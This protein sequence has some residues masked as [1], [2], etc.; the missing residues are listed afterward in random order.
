[1]F[2]PKLKGAKI[3][4]TNPNPTNNFVAQ[5]ITLNNDDYNVLEIIYLQNLTQDYT[6]SQ[7]FLKTTGTVLISTEAASGLGLGVRTRK[8]DYNSNNLIVQD[9][10]AS[11]GG[12]GGKTYN[13]LCVPLYII[14]YKTGLF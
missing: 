11:N 7:R 8:I 6:L 3:L 4:W 2:N 13:D 5:T 1:M 14:G 12:T 9:C 10:I